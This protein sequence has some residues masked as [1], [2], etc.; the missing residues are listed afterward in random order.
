MQPNSD[1]VFTSSLPA[2]KHALKFK[3]L[4]LVVPYLR[5]HFLDLGWRS[6]GGT[7]NKQS[8]RKIRTVLLTSRQAWFLSQ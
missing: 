3:M 5:T 6:T 1:G 4:E 7:A 2:V 8:Q